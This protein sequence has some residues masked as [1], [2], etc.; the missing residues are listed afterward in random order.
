MSR[1]RVKV[2]ELSVVQYVSRYF[3]LESLYAP[4]RGQENLHRL[5]VGVLD[6]PHNTKHK[7]YL[8]KQQ[9]ELAGRLAGCNF[10]ISG[11]ANLSFSVSFTTDRL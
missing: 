7:S 3:P 1:P 11:P 5:K 2:M 8:E 4:W 6:I 9:H 10:V